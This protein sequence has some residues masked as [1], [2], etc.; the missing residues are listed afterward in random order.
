MSPC[1]TCLRRTPKVVE[2]ELGGEVHELAVCARCQEK[3]RRD[4]ARMRRRFEKLLAE[5]MSRPLAN[6][7]MARWFDA[8]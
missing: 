7:V 8:Q 3:I 4:L 2:V 1:L 5:G 6:R